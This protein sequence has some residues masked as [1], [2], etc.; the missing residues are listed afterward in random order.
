MLY[1]AENKR[2]PLAKGLASSQDFQHCQL[3]PVLAQ[4]VIIGDVLVGNLQ[5]VSSKAL[6]RKVI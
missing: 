5:R 4:E 1:Y 3:S 6:H 2:V